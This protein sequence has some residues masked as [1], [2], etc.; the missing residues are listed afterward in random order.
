M[1]SKSILTACGLLIAGSAVALVLGSYAVAGLLLAGGIL[2]GLASMGMR[3]EKEP[4]QIPTLDELS[5]PSKIR[6][7]PIVKLRQEIKRLMEQHAGNA[8]IAS[9]QADMELEVD[10]IVVRAV[11]ILD[12]KR[13]VQ[14]MAAPV[15]RAR[16]MVD[17]LEEKAR[18]EQD[19]QARSSIE[20]ALASRREELRILDQLEISKKRLEA[21]LD[22]AE[23]TLAE[24]RSQII[25]AVAESPEQQAREELEPFS[26]MAERLRNLSTSM[27]ESI[28]TV[29]TKWA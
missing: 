1:A 23:S 12:T 26:E 9:I 15:A 2:A 5:T 10:A 29:S 22:E 8:A 19:A 28:E 11:Q 25:R 21:N 27:E 20:A 16:V 14:K 18:R 3:E 24:L 13:K 17:E 4:S 6:L 7:K